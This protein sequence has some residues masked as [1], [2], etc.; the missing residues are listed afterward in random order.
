MAVPQLLLD[1]IRF[2]MALGAP[3]SLVALVLAGIALRREGT[4]SFCVGGGGFCPISCLTSNTEAIASPIPAMIKNHNPTLPALVWTWDQ[5]TITNAH[6]L[7]AQD[8]NIS[9]STQA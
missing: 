8:T 6:E 2:L 9:E 5:M 1:A 7:M 4:T 3:A